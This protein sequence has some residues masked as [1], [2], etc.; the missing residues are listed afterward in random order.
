M[1]D[2]LAVVINMQERGSRLIAGRMARFLS[3]FYRPQTKLREG[4]VFTPV[5]DSVDGVGS[6]QGGFCPGG[7]CSEGALSRG[8]SVWGVSVEETPH[9]VASRQCVSY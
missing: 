1:S 9:T 8:V 4:N 7:L 2:M 6:V 5:C 3:S